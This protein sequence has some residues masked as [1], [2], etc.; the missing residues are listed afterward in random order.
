[1]RRRLRWALVLAVI[2][3]GVDGAQAAEF[4]AVV[5]S[6]LN[7]SERQ[8][9]VYVKGNSMRQEFPTAS[10]VTT[11]IYLGDKHLAWLLMPEK[12][13]YLEMPITAEMT[14]DLMQLAKDRAH[15]TFLTTETVNGYQADKFETAFKT[16]GGVT[17]HFMWVAKK[18]GMPIKILS[19]DNS[20][21]REYRDI[22]EGELPDT[23]FS[24]PAG[25]Q[26]LSLPAN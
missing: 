19:L 22:K 20:F 1:M 23:L 12:K 16:N 4:S 3:L 13:M 24:P 5:I 14:K 9:R 17:K 25:Y 21:S 15:M 8:G 10:G 26:K 6:R 11:V 2:G 7:G 18:L